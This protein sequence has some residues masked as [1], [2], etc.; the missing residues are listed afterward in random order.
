MVNKINNVT[1]FTSPKC[2]CRSVSD[3]AWEVAKLSEI[4]NREK[5]NIIVF[6]NPFN[7]LISGFLNKYVEHTKYVD[8]AKRKNPRVDLHS[9]E[10]F[11][12]ELSSNGLKLIDK[13]HFTSQI[14]AYKRR[15]FDL[16]FNSEDLEP[17]QNYINSMFLT[18]VEMP[19]RVNKYGAKNLG[20]SPSAAAADSLPCDPWKLDAGRLLELI[21][22][23]QTPAYSDFYNPSLKAIAKAFYHDDFSFLTAC[24]DRGLID[25]G[26]HERLT[27]I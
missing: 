7:R 19:F 1:I 9:F 23:K 24:L 4:R 20:E 25:S 17:L 11:L 18:S 3:F 26:F 8:D 16:V 21:K 10:N 22:S 2:S 6:R 13:L 27:T 14:S 12:G 15:T 5:V